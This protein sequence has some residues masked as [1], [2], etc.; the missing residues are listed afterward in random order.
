MNA[1]RVP[2]LRNAEEPMAFTPQE[3]RRGAL[4]TWITF[5]VL[6]ELLFIVITGR[7]A[8]S[9][10]PSQGSSSGFPE[11]AVAQAIGS[12]LVIAA[13]YCVLV[14]LVGG[15][16]SGII[17]IAL[18]PLARM[19][20]R[21]LARVRAPRK[22]LAA[23]G[24]LGAITG[25]AVGSV[26]AVLLFSGFSGAPVVVLVMGGVAAVLTGISAAVG[27]RCAARDLLHER[28]PRR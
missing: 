21:R 9:A 12:A 27:W 4:W 19:L 1:D 6:L 11:G 23:F 17:T 13:L 3:L 26:L 20:G 16:I 10:S 25:A 2:S 18:T 28:G 7:T 24:L 5:M 22:H 8:L 14:A 15:V